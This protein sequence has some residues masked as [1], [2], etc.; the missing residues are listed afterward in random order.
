MGG[1]FFGLTPLF[2]SRATIAAFFSGVIVRFGLC[3][4][5]PNRNGCSQQISSLPAFS[6]SR[7]PLQFFTALVF[8]SCR[9]CAAHSRQC[10]LILATTDRISST[11][12][13]S[14]HTFVQHFSGVTPLHSR[15]SLFHACRAVT[16]ITGSSTFFSR[17][18]LECCAFFSELDEDFERF[19]G[20]GAGDICSE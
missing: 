7:S 11:F 18:I 3:G 4:F 19:D 10:C 8:V 17:Y 20:F 1:S 5:L 15:H 13:L 12:G 14:L 6:L 16:V 2:R 9:F